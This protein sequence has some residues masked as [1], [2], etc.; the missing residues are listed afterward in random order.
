MLK[1]TAGPIFVVA[2]LATA[3]PLAHT[4]SLTLSVAKARAAPGSEAAVSVQV[5]NAQGMGPLQFD[6]VFDPAILE[7]LDPA[8]TEGSLPAGAMIESNCVEPGRLRVAMIS[9]KAVTGSGE[10]AVCHFR[11]TGEAGRSGSLQLENGRAWDHL[12]NL[13][14]LVTTEDG[15]FDV[16][17]SGLP[18]PVLLGAA[19]LSL[20]AILSLIARLRR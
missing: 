12:Q 20:I 4:A 8:V 1:R 10:V 17:S 11:V 7:P 5:T 2:L 15:S 16:G 3:A 14:M 6:L 13:E 18:L 9:G 19:A